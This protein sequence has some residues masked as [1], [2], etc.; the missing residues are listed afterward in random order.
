[1]KAT[2]PRTGDADYTFVPTSPE[3]VADEA[4]RLRAAQPAWEALGFAGRAKVLLTFAEALEEHTA[5]IGHALAIDTGRRGIA[6]IEVES[7]VRNIR[8]WAARGP[9]LFEALPHEAT[10]SATPGVSIVSRCSRLPT[11]R[12][13]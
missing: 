5:G 8:K 11:C 10:P 4:T 13:I 3:G 12:A 9:E 7:V 1:M 2:N 6:Q